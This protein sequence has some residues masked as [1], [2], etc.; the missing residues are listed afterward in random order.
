MGDYNIPTGKL[1]KLAAAITSVR[2]PRRSHWL[3]IASGYFTPLEAKKLIV[4]VDKQVKL[5]GIKVYIDK[6]EALRIGRKNLVNF[7]RTLGRPKVFT[8]SHSALFHSKVYA[9]A[10]FDRKGVVTDGS[11]VI[12]SANLTGNGITNDTGNI[13]S[14]LRTSKVTEIRKFVRSLDDLCWNSVARLEDDQL[15]DDSTLNFALLN[16]GVFVHKWS[17]SINSFLAVKHNLSSK[18]RQAES[19]DPALKQT[20][21]SHDSQTASQQYLKFHPSKA[22]TLKLA[23]F[24]GK[25]GVECRLGHWVPRLAVKNLLDPVQYKAVRDQFKQYVESNLDTQLRKVQDD[26]EFLLE[27][28][29]IEEAQISPAQSLRDK[30]YG[31]RGLL[32]SKNGRIERLLLPLEDFEL[33]YDPQDIESIDALADEITE[34]AISKKRQKTGVKAWLAGHNQRSVTALRTV[35]EEA[36]A[37]TDS[38]G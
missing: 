29:S 4:Q 22:Q 12:G 13:E 28:E 38:D 18:G 27:K 36:I 34:V 33:P 31:R 19:G 37:R 23:N 10:Y 9:L 30:I 32:R 8:V 6:K 17:S 3:Y 7:Q 14:I 16:E 26:Y 1:T 20:G 5:A 21:F 2:H 24:R 11:L 35:V 15:A 25:Y